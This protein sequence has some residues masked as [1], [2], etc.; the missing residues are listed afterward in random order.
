MELILNIAHNP[1]G[2]VKDFI[3]NNYNFNNDK[4]KYILYIGLFILLKRNGL[5][6]KMNSKIGTLVFFFPK[7]LYSY[8]AIFYLYGFNFILN[9]L[10]EY[11]NLLYP[12]NKLIKW[13]HDENYTVD[14]LKNRKSKDELETIK[15]QILNREVITFD[16]V[17]L[18]QLFDT[19]EPAK[20]SY[21]VGKTYRGS[22]VRSNCYLDI[23]DVILVKP[24]EALGFNWGKRYRNDYTG[25]PLLLSY[26]QKAWAPIP[27]W[28]NV[29]VREINYREQVQSTMVYDH[30][31]WM[32]YFRHLG[33]T[34]DGQHMMLGLWSSHALNGGFFTLTETSV[35]AN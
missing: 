35:E 22:I 15:Q 1:F 16:E 32:D 31:P 3:T 28:G 7:F 24:L 12:K 11:Q 26:N 25:D 21:V 20:N 23:V 29:S 2:L 6:M 19:L 18:Y 17:D 30:Q 9:F 14:K 5:N 8:I 13:D 10:V 27:A 34:P 4:N 33:T